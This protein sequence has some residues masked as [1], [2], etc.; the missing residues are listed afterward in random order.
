MPLGALRGQ[1]SKRSLMYERHEPLP[2][3]TLLT[4]QATDSARPDT[5]DQV[6]GFASS[7]SWTGGQPSLQKG[8]ILL[9]VDAEGGVSRRTWNFGVEPLLSQIAATCPDHQSTPSRRDWYDRPMESFKEGGGGR[10]RRTCVVDI[11]AIGL[12]PT[13]SPRGRIV[14]IGSRHSMSAP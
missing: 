10:R 11:E 6:G 3:A 12:R 9:S 7:Q 4:Q 13:T 1:I 14:D 8:P 2:A 5:S